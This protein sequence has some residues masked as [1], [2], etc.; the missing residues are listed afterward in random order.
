MN[1]N[2]GATCSSAQSTPSV[3]S[4]ANRLPS[5]PETTP[6]MADSPTMIAMT[7][8]RVAPIARKTPISRRRS[9]TCMKK[10]WAM[11]MALMITMTKAMPSSTKVMTNIAVAKLAPS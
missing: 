10:L 8:A 2:F 5:V 3:A 7:S 1:G 4:H 11:L 9:V 6:M